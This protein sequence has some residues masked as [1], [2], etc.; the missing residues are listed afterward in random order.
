[1]L[2]PAKTLDEMGRIVFNDYVDATL[3]AI[4]VA[5]VFVM[6]FYGTREALRALDSAKATTSEIGG[7]AAAAE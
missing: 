5:I 3:A 2:A 4:F 7:A 6:L 1:M